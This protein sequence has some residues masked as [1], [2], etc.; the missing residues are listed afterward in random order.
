MFVEGEFV[1]EIET[2]PTNEKGRFNGDDFVLERDNKGILWF[3]LTTCEM[4]EVGFRNI[5]REARLEK[6]CGEGSE[7]LGEDEDVPCRVVGSD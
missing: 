6:I 2:E 7:G 4:Y 1:V 5:N 3:S